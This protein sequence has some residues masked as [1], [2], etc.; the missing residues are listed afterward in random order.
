ML[1]QVYDDDPDL[2]LFHFVAAAT[3]LPLPKNACLVLS[4]LY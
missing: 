1:V 3:P 2:S 4:C